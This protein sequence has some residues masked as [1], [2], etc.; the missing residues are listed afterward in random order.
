MKYI[1]HDGVM[2]FSISIVV[3]TFKVLDQLYLKY[4]ITHPSA[5]ALIMCIINV[6]MY[7]RWSSKLDGLHRIGDV[8]ISLWS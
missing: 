6:K 8:L 5:S 2:Y 3:C 1:Q 4:S 7:S